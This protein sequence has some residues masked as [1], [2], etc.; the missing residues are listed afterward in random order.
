MPT[1][2]DMYNCI[3][4]ER[5]RSGLTLEEFSDKIGVAEKT[6]RNWRDSEKPI[7]SDVLIKISNLFGCSID[8]LL[9]LS[10]KVRIN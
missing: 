6:Y 9:C 2:V 8:Y 7:S 3:E 10:D 5:A 1:T 4:A